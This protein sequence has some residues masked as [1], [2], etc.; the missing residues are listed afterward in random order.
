MTR[1]V[2]AL[3][4]LRLRCRRRDVVAAHISRHRAH[5]HHTACSLHTPL[6]EK[7]RQS[8]ANGAAVLRVASL[9]VDIFFRSQWACY[10]G[11]EQRA[12]GKEQKAKSPDPDFILL[13]LDF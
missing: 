7:L 8:P 3:C 1:T 9:L 13:T 6:P 4:R 5:R 2:S 11:K 12:K 10:T